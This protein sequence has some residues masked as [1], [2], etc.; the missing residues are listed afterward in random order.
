MTANYTSPL[1]RAWGLVRCV[2]NMCRTVNKKYYYCEG[3]AAL[4]EMVG[5]IHVKGCNCCEHTRFEMECDPSDHAYPQKFCV[6]CGNLEKV[7]HRAD[8]RCL[9]ERRRLRA[10]VGVEEER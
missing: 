5:G 8:G 2:E 7:G 4:L 1:K 9:E 6:V 10:V 3:H